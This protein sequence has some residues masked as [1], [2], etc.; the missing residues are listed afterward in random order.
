MA[1]LTSLSVVI[2]ALNEARTLPLLLADLA[3][4]GEPLPITVVD[5]GSADSTASVAKL[6][7]ATVIH[8]AQRGRGQQLRLGTSQTQ[9]AWLLV[10]HADSR[11]HPLWPQAVAEAMKTPHQAWTFD[12]RVAG[13]RPMLRVLEAA[14]ALRSRWLQRPYGDQG[15]LIHRQ[16]LE[17]VGGYRPIPIME[18][19][20]LA[21]RLSA[22]T[23]LR[24]LGLPLLT[25]DR[26]WTREGIL[27]IAWRNACLRHRW[28]QG[29][30]P[31]RLAM[32]YRAEAGGISWR[33][34]RHSGA[35]EAPT[36][37]PGADKN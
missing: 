31:E 1:E 5:A 6:A 9:G 28:K 33:T 2:P 3:R 10:L 4:W 19:L 17:H 15:L 12:F 23:Q 13:D 30:D 22:E 37:S 27:R 34:R 21:E 24:R 16:L 32:T 20:D 26:R 35:L 11:L 29:E 18:D 8:S 7:G 25:S 14:V 36:P